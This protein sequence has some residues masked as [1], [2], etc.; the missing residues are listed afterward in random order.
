MACTDVTVRFG[1]VVAVSSVSLELHAG[2][3]HALVGQNGAGKT[4]LAR[5][6]AGLQVQGTGSV[7][8]NSTNITP[9]DYRA[10]RRAGVDMVHQHASLIPDLT[11]A[12]ALELTASQP[13]RRVAYRRVDVERRWSAFLSGRGVEVDVGRKVR[14]LSV[15]LTQSIE[16]ARSTPGP[17]GL[18]V[19]DE[20]TSVLA[21]ERVAALF[22]RLRQIT[23]EGV[24]VL[25]VL[26][27][28]GE[29]RQV[30]DTVTVLRQGEV[31]LPP[32]PVGAVDD[33]GL[34]EHII[35]STAQVATATVRP[36]DGRRG[37]NMT[38]HDACAQAAEG[39][40]P[41]RDVQLEVASGQIVGVAGVE[42]N[43]QR[44]LVEVMTGLRPLDSGRF[45]CLD[46]EF[47]GLSVSQRRARGLRVIPFDR[48]VEGVRGDLPLWHNVVGWRAQQF[49]W[50]PML[51]VLSTRAMRA[52]A[53]QRL[54]RFNVVYRDVDQPAGS[55]SGGNV[56]RL[57]LARELPDALA[58]VAAHPT[59]GL[60]ISGT[61]SVWESLSERSEAGC[62]VM[63][64]SSD[65]DEL[66]EHCS[67]LVVMRGGAIAGEHGRPFNRQA[68]G[69]DMTGASV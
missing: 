1:D 30:A 65:L 34:S 27:K 20:P 35:G 19:L 29:V 43:G 61:R 15:E 59:R 12:E 38:L 44:T 2:G 69:R 55:L 25:V 49:R 10:A 14:D 48:N 7:A 18:L 16:I 5:V 42:G 67:R 57:I 23:D 63:V 52:E 33:P 40:S 22:A 21:P 24:T 26:H 31:V 4:T 68:I 32:T 50:R 28:L 17:G 47:V 36:A 58:L 62:P 46:T 9:G 41:L 60:D 37:S 53:R 45:E 56:Q 13:S 39:D 64:V 11:V 51:P 8:V 3:I 6:I 66:L 54:E